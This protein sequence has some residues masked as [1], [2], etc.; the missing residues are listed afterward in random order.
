MPKAT[1]VYVYVCIIPSY[2]QICYIALD[3]DSP[4]CLTCNSFNQVL[5][6]HYRIDFNDCVACTVLLLRL[7]RHHACGDV[8]PWCAVQLAVYCPLPVLS[9]QANTHSELLWSVLCPWQPLGRLP[10][11]ERT[12]GSSVRPATLHFDK[13]MA[14][15]PTRISLWIHTHVVFVCVSP[16]NTDIY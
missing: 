10:E 16:K 9:A 4:V 5:S 2:W 14:D 15:P 13:Q 1:H 7:W 3:S 8:G 12:R 6:V 11:D